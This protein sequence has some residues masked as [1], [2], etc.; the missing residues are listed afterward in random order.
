MFILTDIYTHE[1]VFFNVY[2]QRITHDILD[3]LVNING[4]CFLGWTIPDEMGSKQG[5]DIFMFQSCNAVIN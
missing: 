4:W 1:L 3:I 5:S 2:S